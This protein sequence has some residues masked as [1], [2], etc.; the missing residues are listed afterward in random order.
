MENRSIRL[1]QGLK[2]MAN[3]HSKMVDKKRYRE[4]PERRD[5]MQQKKKDQ[6]LLCLHINKLHKEGMTYVKIAELLDRKYK[7][8][9][10]LGAK[11]NLLQIYYECGHGKDR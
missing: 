4:D 11:G 8:V 6:E 1:G 3:Y 5:L 10:R 7:Q 2:M 9:V